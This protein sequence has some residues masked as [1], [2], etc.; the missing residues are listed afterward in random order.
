VPQRFHNAVAL[1]T[2]AARLSGMGRAIAVRLASEGAAVVVNGLGRAPTPVP[3]R[4]QE[5]GWKGLASVVD[6]IESAGGSALAVEGD[7]GKATDAAAMV[8][9][10]IERF[11]RLD[12]VVNNAATGRWGPTLLDLDD[13]EWDRVLQTNL[14]GTY[15]MSRAG[16]K[17][18]I[19]AGHGGSIVNISSAAGRTG[20]ARMGA[21]SP[22]KFGVIGLTQAM[23]L[24]LAEHGIRV[25]GI[26]PA[27]IETDMERSIFGQISEETGT[28]LERTVAAR[29]RRVPLGHMGTPEDVAAAVAF[30]GSA[31]A[32]FVTGQT[33]NVSGGPPFG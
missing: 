23:A 18:M 15:L 6:E 10:A 30:L 33:I 28:S 17:A 8:A 29:V 4:E 2:G 26:A 19:D 20:M 25:N 22:A 31:D 3:E 1:V 12:V 32:K 7:V 16:A 14:T 11:G 21:Y 24:E 5:L 13:D 27:A 9:A